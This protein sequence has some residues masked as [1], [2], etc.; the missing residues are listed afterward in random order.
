MGIKPRKK[1]Q[2][3]RRDYFAAGTLVVWDVDV[4]KEE[5]I[6]VYRADN[7]EQMQVD[8]RGEVAE[9][10]PALPGWFMP[11]DNLFM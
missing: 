11:V 4:L 5:V 6:R 10:E 3:K 7:P 2:K 1:W 8:H 9:A